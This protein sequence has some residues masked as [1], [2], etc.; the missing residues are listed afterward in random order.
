ME[1]IRSLV[2]AADKTVR[3][4]QPLLDLICEVVTDCL[5]GRYTPEE[6]AANLQSRASIYISE[7]YG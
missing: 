2:Y 7:Q 4:D 3:E 6:A 1:K 5:A